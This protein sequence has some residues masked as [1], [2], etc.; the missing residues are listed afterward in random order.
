MKK[1]IVIKATNACNLS[2]LYCYDRR[3]PRITSDRKTIVVSEVVA[4]LSQSLP[5]PSQILIVLHGGEPL[6]IGKGEFAE[7]VREM[8]CANL[9]GHTFKLAIQT[10]ATLLDDSWVDVLAEANDL[11]GERGIGIS[12]DGPP[13]IND[14]VRVTRDLKGSSELIESAIGR[15]KKHGVDF[16][17]LCVVGTHNVNSPEDVY[18]YFAG[19]SPGFIRFI[20]CFDL[21]ETGQIASYAITPMQYTEFLVRCYDIWLSDRTS[22]IPVDPF[23]SIIANLSGVDSPWCEYE[24]KSKCQGFVLVDDNGGVASCDNWGDRADRKEELSIFSM[25]NS[26]IYDVLSYPAKSTNIPI[27]SKN[28]MRMCLGCDVEDIC[29]GG[30]LAT[31][32]EFLNKNEALYHEYC[33]AK[34]ELIA[35]LERSLSLI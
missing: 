9:Q 21:D 10:N 22:F 23:V 30:C 7:I 18:T 26:K 32:D 13:K 24:K 20:P 16:G 17:L 35:H 2:C 25:S 31:R 27:K 4:L 6:L 28:L 5:V 11:F 33:A 1:S 3:R 15:L 29:C 8:R 12:I 19:L 34:K 14:V